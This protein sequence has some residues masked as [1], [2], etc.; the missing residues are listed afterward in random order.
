MKLFHCLNNVKYRMLKYNPHLFNKTVIKH[1]CKLMIYYNVPYCHSY[2]VLCSK[3]FNTCVY[4]VINKK[5]TLR[6]F[7]NKGVHFPTQS[8]CHQV[9]MWSRTFVF[10]KKM[11]FKRDFN[12]MNSMKKQGWVWSCHSSVFLS[13][14]CFLKSFVWVMRIRKKNEINGLLELSKESLE[15]L[16]R[17]H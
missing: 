12:T 14:G 2:F 15:T 4:K 17:T 7:L 8:L 13:C 3:L 1:L 16:K 5:F 11:Y 10:Y 6:F 9:T